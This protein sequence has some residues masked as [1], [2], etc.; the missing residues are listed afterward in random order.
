MLAVKKED[1]KG[2]ALILSSAYVDPRVLAKAKEKV[3][4]ADKAAAKELQ[5]KRRVLTKFESTVHF[6]AADEKD[7]DRWVQALARVL[8]RENVAALKI[9]KVARGFLSRL[10]IRRLKRLARMKATRRR[11]EV[12][13][14]SFSFSVLV[15]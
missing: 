8:P 14:F 10:R 15:W 4:D 3:K 7:R 11:E 1:K 9:Q 5:A 6:V 13:F 2:F 12:L